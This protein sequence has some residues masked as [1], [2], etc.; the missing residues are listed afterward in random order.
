AHEADGTPLYAPYNLSVAVPAMMISHS[1]AG[2]AEALLT[3]A[4]VAYL[5]ASAPELMSG[6][7]NEIERRPLPVLWG[8]IRLLWII[9]AVLVLL[10]PLG[11]LAPGTGWG[12]WASEQFYGIGLGFIP[13]GLMRWEAIWSSWLLDYSVPGLGPRSGYV[14][15]AII[16][17][18]VILAVFQLITAIGRRSAKSVEKKA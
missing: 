1:I 18:F 10:T 13:K 11:L 14:V 15:S 12:E 7:A 2:L 16:G 17:I 3:A 6:L 8:R 9:V 5:H 4:G